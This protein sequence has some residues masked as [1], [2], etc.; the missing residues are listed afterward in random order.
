MNKSEEAYGVNV[1][2]EGHSSGNVLRHILPWYSCVQA[3]PEKEKRLIVV[4]CTY[5]YGGLEYLGVLRCGNVAKGAH[6]H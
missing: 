1:I 2:L 3:L 4:V 5:G 6:H